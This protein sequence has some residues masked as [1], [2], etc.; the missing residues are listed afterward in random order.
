MEGRRLHRAINST[1]NQNAVKPLY[2]CRYST[3][4]SHASHW[5]CRSMFF[6]FFFPMKNHRKTI[7]NTCNWKL[8]RDHGISYLSLV[9]S[10]H[11][12]SP[13]GSCVYEENK[14]DSLDIP[15][16]TNQKHYITSIYTTVFCILIGCIFYD[17]AQSHVH[18]FLCWFEQIIVQTITK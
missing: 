9:F 17:I 16:D 2:I 8:S 12:H 18:D 11:T 13:K 10:R 15:W 7:E 4:P 3:E 6:F 5:L 1:G 14:S